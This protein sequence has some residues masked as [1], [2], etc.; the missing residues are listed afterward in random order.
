MRLYTKIN[1][2][3]SGMTASIS[4]K[5][6]LFINPDSSLSAAFS[7]KVKNVDG[8]TS[9]LIFSLGIGTSPGTTNYFIL[10]FSILSYTGLGSPPSTVD[11]V[12][13]ELF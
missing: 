1:P 12:V 3:S 7:A 13:Y 2:I 11:P 4:N 5:G 10:P 8:T 6:A 9:D